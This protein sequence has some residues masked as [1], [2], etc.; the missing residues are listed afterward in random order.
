MDMDRAGR[1]KPREFEQLRAL[2]ELAID[3]I[4][5]SKPA[6]DH[7]K[8]RIDP[9]RL[10]GPPAGLQR[11]YRLL[12]PAPANLDDA[13]AKMRDTDVIGPAGFLGDG[14]GF[15]GMRF[16]LA[17][18]AAIGRAVREQARV[19][20]GDGARH[21]QPGMAMRLPQIGQIAVS[22]WTAAP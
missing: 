17:K 16:G 20:N 15:A 5:K 8:Q 21:S 22:I 18:C 13:V 9:R 6:A 12:N 4:G 11:G 14:A 19:Q 10:A 7:G 1:S 3:G 2:L